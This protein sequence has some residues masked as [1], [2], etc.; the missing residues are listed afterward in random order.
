MEEHPRHPTL[1]HQ[2]ETASR[3]CWR[4]LEAAEQARDVMAMAVLL[5]VSR[6]GAYGVELWMDDLD[7]RGI[8]AD[9]QASRPVESREEQSGWMDGRRWPQR[10]VLYKG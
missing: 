7:G 1:H 6:R 5:P 8:A 10:G 4:A 9:E 3:H 2:T